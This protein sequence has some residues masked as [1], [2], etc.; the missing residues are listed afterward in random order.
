MKLAMTLPILVVLGCA[1]E[2]EDLTPAT[3]AAE[4]QGQP[5][6]TLLDRLSTPTGSTVDFCAFDGGVAVLESAP[7]HTPAYVNDLE[8][9]WRCPSDLY[10]ELAKG[11]EVPAE[12]KEDCRLRTESGRVPRTAD[13][14]PLTPPRPTRRSHYCAGGSGDDDFVDERCSMMETSAGNEDWYDSMWW[15]HAVSATQSQR[16]AS[17]QLGHKG[18]KIRALLASCNGTSNYRLS[19][20]TGGW[21]TDVDTDVLSGWYVDGTLY[22]AVTDKDLR[23]N[24]DTYGNAWYRNTGMF[25]DFEWP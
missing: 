13:A 11:A 7:E 1:A 15:C 17:S 12:L 25:G 9:H 22:T 8:R 23:F 20:Y 4:Q 3:S 10:A 2:D 24:G 19:H 6:T 18:D 16:T 5:C 14:P 21:D